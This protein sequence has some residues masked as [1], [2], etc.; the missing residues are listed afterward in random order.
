MACP[1]FH[2]VAR[3]VSELRT[4]TAMLPL[5]DAWAGVCEANPATGNATPD[6]AQLRPLCNLGYARGR[7]ARFP[8]EDPG[9][10]AVRFCISGDDGATLKISYVLER[11]HHPFAYGP[12]EYSLANLSFVESPAAPNVNCQAA[13]YVESYL[14]RKKEASAR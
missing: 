12:L 10:D 7:C 6:A 8:A 14:L 2:P 5:G 11:D 13:A 3:C 9:A 1:Y 4:E